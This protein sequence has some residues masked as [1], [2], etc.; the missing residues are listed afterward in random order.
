MSRERHMVPVWFFIGIL[1]VL[2]GATVLVASWLDYSK[3]TTVALAQYHPGIYGG[4]FLLVIGGF[5]AIWF[6]PGR[7]KDK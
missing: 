3:P 2:Y 4:I 5:Y 6:R 7:H 1:L